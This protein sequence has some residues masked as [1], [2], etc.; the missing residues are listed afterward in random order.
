MK[1]ND[2]RRTRLVNE[3]LDPAKVQLPWDGLEKKLV[4]AYVKFW[5]IVAD[6]PHTS[7]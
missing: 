1:R 5:E 2:P 6:G 4:G 7:C 3:P